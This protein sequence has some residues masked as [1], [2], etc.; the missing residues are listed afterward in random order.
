MTK[1]SYLKIQMHTS[2]RRPS[3]FPWHPLRYKHIHA[4]VRGLAGT[5]ELAAAC[6][7][8]LSD[9]ETLPRVSGSSAF[10]SELGSN[11]SLGG[12]YPTRSR[13]L[14]WATGP[15]A[16]RLPVSKFEPLKS[17]PPSYP[18]FFIGTLVL[19]RPTTS[20]LLRISR[21]PGFP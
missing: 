6:F 13:D 3:A 2:R 16:R 1:V 9:G 8:D 20:T 21:F 10:P 11:F 19:N 5:R 7:P 12:S 15:S 18:L 17:L 4:T 14:A